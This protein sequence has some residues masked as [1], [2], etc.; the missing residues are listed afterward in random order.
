MIPNTQENK[1]KYLRWV[2]AL[3]LFIICVA[4]IRYYVVV[5][6]AIVDYYGDV[7]HHSE[8]DRLRRAGQLTQDTVYCRNV[9]PNLFTPSQYCFDTEAEMEAS[10]RDHVG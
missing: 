3:V 6:D 10:Y 5:T 8:F 7:M 1:P 9:P 4:A 2:I